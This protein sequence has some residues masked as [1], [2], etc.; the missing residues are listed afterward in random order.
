M[1]SL[2]PEALR[3]KGEAQLQN[4]QTSEA[5]STFLAAKAASEQLNER[6]QYWLILARLAEFEMQQENLEQAAKYR[7]EAKDTITCIADSITDQ[8]LRDK[9]LSSTEVQQTMSFKI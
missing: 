5:S 9:F 2:L 7:Q 1:H 4:K 8:K 6:R 3:I